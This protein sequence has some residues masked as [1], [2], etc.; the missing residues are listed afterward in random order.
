LTCVVIRKHGNELSF[1]ASRDAI[2]I[3]RITIEQITGRAW[4][5][6]PFSP[7]HPQCYEDY[8][9]PITPGDPLLVVD[10]NQYIYSGV[11]LVE[12]E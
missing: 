5:F 6:A 2:G 8:I 4:V 3:P 10:D 7:L 9:A 1:R 12:A 11:W